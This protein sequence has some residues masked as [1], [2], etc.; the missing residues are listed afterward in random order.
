M[1]R[2]IVKKRPSPKETITEAQRKKVL[3]HIERLAEHALEGGPATPWTAADKEDIL[4][5]LRVL[6]SL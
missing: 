2:K 1:S 5:R 6:R 4:R 3:E